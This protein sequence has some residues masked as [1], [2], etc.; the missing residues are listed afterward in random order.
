LVSNT[1][2]VSNTV[3]APKSA[4]IG[5]AKP[6]SVIRLGDLLQL[7]NLLTQPLVLLDKPVG[8]RS[9]R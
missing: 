4:G 1:S 6:S 8:D 2:V 5:S 3:C 7:R 9:A